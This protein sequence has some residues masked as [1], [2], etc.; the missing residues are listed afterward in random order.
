MRPDLDD[1][2]YALPANY[3]GCLIKFAAQTQ[4][5]AVTVATPPIGGR[6]I[7]EMED[8]AGSAIT[9]TP[10]A[11][12]ITGVLVNGLTGGSTAITCASKA[13]VAF[14]AI[15]LVGTSIELI[16]DGVGWMCRGFSGLDNSFA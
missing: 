11:G 6:Y 12:T 2:T 4:A 1:T 5:V 15:A 10:A 3:E 16:Y 9:F 7:F 8:T 14:E 13:D